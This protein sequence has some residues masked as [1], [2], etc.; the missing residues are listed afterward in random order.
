MQI[1]RAVL[2]IRSL[3]PGTRLGVWVN[4]CKRRCEGC[5]SQRLQAFEP[6]NEVD[7][8]EYFDEFDLSLTDGVTVSGGEPFEQAEELCRLLDYLRRRGVR[9]ILVYTGYTLEELRGR[10]DPATD[11]A[12][13]RIDVLIDGPYVRELDNGHGNLKGS[14]NQRVIFLNEDVCGAYK[15]Y[16]RDEREMQEFY[17]GNTLLSVGIPDEEYI[18]RFERKE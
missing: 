14:E 1:E 10:G 12:L 11:G 13:E 4:G 7:I 17:F 3:G 2:G 15:Q 16:Y 9:D 18:K 5:V 6:R 8:E